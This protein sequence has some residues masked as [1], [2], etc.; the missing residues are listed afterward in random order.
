MLRSVNTIP[1]PTI[2][3]NGMEKFC[4]FVSHFDPFIAWFFSKTFFIFEIDRDLCLK[5]KLKH[6][7]GGGGQTLYDID[8]FFD[9]SYF[10]F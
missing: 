4:V 8:F 2:D 9:V 3:G 1:I 10:A 7:V 5:L 6:N